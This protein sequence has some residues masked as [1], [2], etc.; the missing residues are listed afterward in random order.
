MSSNNLEHDNDYNKKVIFLINN[1]IT[2]QYAIEYAKFPISTMTYLV[3]LSKLI[4]EKDAFN[5]L[6]NIPHKTELKLNNLNININNIDTIV[7]LLKYNFVWGTVLIKKN[8]H[9]NLVKIL[10]N[11]YKEF[12]Y[13]ELCFIN[14]I[15]NDYNK[16]FMI[17]NK[18][19]NDTL[20]YKDNYYKLKS[21]GVMHN[22]AYS[23]CKKNDII[24]NNIL[25]LIK[26]DYNSISF[27]ET[28]Y[29]LNEEQMDFLRFS[30][31]GYSTVEQFNKYSN[32]IFDNALNKIFMFR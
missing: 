3:D 23:W 7:R 18:N 1:N 6:T 9:I 19:I 16:S 29:V 31:L 27:L 11:E 24:I 14:E 22:Y 28:A 8:I 5:I 15:T 10:L 21:A 32:N 25:E 17:I 4:N 13:F 30:R 20:K 2:Q 26:Y 12:Y